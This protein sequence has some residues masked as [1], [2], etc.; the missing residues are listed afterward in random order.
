[1]SSENDGNQPY[2]NQACSMAPNGASAAG[3]TNEN[4]NSTW[5]QNISDEIDIYEFADSSDNQLSFLQSGDQRFRSTATEMCTTRSDRCLHQ[6]GTSETSTG[7]SP[8]LYDEVFGCCN[9]RQSGET[10]K[11]LIQINQG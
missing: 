9:C 5:C 4:E 11:E 10:P 6:S 1:M 3:N 8:D 7:V 2:V